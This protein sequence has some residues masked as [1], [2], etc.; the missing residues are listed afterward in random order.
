[1]LRVDSRLRLVHVLRA[2]ALVVSTIFVVPI[3][4][5]VCLFE[6]DGKRGYR[7]AQW[8]MAFNLWVSGV[9]VRVLG[10][11]NLDPTRQ[12]VFMSNH[13]SAADIV[14]LGWALWAFQIRFVAKKE[15]LRVPVFGWG[16]AALKNIVI[17]RSN[18]VQAVRSYAVAGQRIR[19]GI[20]VVVFPEGTRGAGEELLPFKKGGF[21]LAMETGTP[22]VPI[23]VVGTTAIMAKHSLKI[24]SGE[25]E[26]RIGEP[27]E[28]VGVPLK[29]RNQ[30]VARVREAIA[31]LG[32]TAAPAP[33]S[34]GSSSS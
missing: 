24:E 11:E 15:L 19:R 16:L 26:V 10:L 9:R 23:A 20:S 12:Y 28:T 6:Q 14:A 4:V 34:Q 5:V 2:L 21:V 30:I 32:N 33:A 3:I 17:D 18:H 31:A 8:W 1:M 22:I 27:I 29:D 13:R 7:F 25:V